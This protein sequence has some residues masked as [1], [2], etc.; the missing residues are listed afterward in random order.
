MQRILVIKLSALGDIMQAEGA[1]HDIR[2]HH[3]DAEIT[4]MTMPAYRRLMGRCPWVDRVI[5]DPRESRFRLDRMFALRQQLRRERFDLVY[6]LQQVGRTDFYYRWFLQGTPWVGGAPGCSCY[7]LRP[8][9]RC[10]ADHFALCLEKAG[11]PVG[12]TRRCDVSW[13]ADDVDDILARAGLDQPYAV[14]VPGGSGEHPEK[15]WPYFAE[16][17]ELLLAQ[18][19]RLATVPGPDELDLCRQIGVEMLL[20]ADGRWLDVFR[21][22]GVLSKAAFVVG[23]DT[24]PT[25]IAVHLQIPGL[26][27]YS[28]HSSATFSGIQYGRFEWLERANLTD[29]PVTEV[30]DRLTNLRRHYRLP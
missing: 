2:L 17:A 24:G 12:H 28:D 27:L 9:D 3:A 6:D 7:C 20:E 18:G 4:V 21:L 16:L 26:A 14:L 25:H 29:L 22:A 19:L 1:M 13:L 11:V 8:A 15:R 5:I 23:N 10:A 30:W